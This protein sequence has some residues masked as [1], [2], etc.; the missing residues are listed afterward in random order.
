MVKK[1]I[2]NINVY[3]TG[4]QIE[5]RYLLTPAFIYR[6]KTLKNV[7]GNKPIKCAFFDKKIML[8]ISTSEDLFEIGSIFK[9]LKNPSSFYKFYSQISAIFDM[10]EHL[11]M[12]DETVNNKWLYTKSK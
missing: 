3:T 10:V 12:Y 11:K 5:A 1:K 7:F 2:K 6:F 8:A 9:S 4:S